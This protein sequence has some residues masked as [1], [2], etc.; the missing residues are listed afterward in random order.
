M[1]VVSNH[2]IRK[3]IVSIGVSHA[4]A[5]HIHETSDKFSPFENFIFK[6]S[7]FYNIIKFRS[8]RNSDN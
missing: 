3:R 6:D 5:C 1:F 2:Q 7:H 8:L 4:I